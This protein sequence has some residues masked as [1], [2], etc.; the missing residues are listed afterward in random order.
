MNTEIY[1]SVKPEIKMEI[2]LLKFV[3]CLNMQIAIVISR[4]NMLGP[5][6]E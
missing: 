2:E 1:F 4:P 6:F 3:K 5:W